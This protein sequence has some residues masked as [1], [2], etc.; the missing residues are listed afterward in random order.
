MKRILW[1]AVL[2]GLVFPAQARLPVMIVAP[3]VVAPPPALMPGPA[4]TR[5]ATVLR[6]RPQH[7]STVEGP[8]PAGASLK[9]QVRQ[10]NRDGAWWYT[11]YQHY[12]GWVQE[13]ALSQ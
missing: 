11:E 5:Q 4:K 8:V 1:A 3:P 12:S 9:L 10:S 7:Q 6:A 13:S 2:A